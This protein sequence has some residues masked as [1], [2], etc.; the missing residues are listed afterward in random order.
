MKKKV[1]YNSSYF[2]NLFNKVDTLGTGA[3]GNRCALYYVRTKKEAEEN[4]YPSISNKKFFSL[5][6]MFN[7]AFYQESTP[8]TAHVFRINDGFSNGKF[9]PMELGDTPR[10]RILVALEIVK[11]SGLG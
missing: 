1:K 2:I 6:S 3:I 5:A 11:G 7:E 4:K 8:D 10:E 9:D